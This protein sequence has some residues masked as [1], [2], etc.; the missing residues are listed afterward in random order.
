MTKSNEIFL[1]LVDGIT[2]NLRRSMARYRTYIYLSPLKMILFAFLGM[3]F[4]D[5]P[6]SDY[7]N[8]FTD[9]WQIHSLDFNTIEYYEE[10]D[11]VKTPQTSTTAMVV[12]LL[13]QITA[14]YVCYILAKFVCKVQMQIFSFSFPLGLV[15]PPL[16]L[17]LLLI[18]SSMR[19]SN[20]CA[21]HGILPDYIFFIEE[22]TKGV[23]WYFKKEKIWI[24]M[25]CWASQ[26][27]LTYHIWLPDSKIKNLPTEKLFVCPWYC[28]L[29]VEQCIT[30]NR[31]R[32]HL[33]T[34]YQILY[35]SE[36]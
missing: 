30:L 4:G 31:R 1:V 13:V 15:G 10:N 18:M 9:G 6:L 23:F 2:Q 22:D 24:W 35:V 27:A 28:G 5:Y 12:I 32:P 11:I 16:S 14:S 26:I 20:T 7:F 8:K 21:F 3:S 29:L 25:I 36:L 19:L 34:E 33:T 17:G